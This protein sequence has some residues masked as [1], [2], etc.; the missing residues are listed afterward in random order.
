[1]LEE[2]I[3]KS[4]TV[5]IAFDPVPV[6]PILA[7][8]S[9]K[10]G[11]ARPTYHGTI[12]EYTTLC[13]KE[14]PDCSKGY[15]AV[16]WFII[17]TPFQDIDRERERICLGCDKKVDKARFADV[18]PPAQTRAQ[19]ESVLQWQ[20]NSSLRLAKHQKTSTISP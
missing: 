11:T 8:G 20:G 13:K 18:L 7:V 16:N 14:I 10:H 5:R 12:D 19:K 15:D 2:V 9:Q 3:Y 17:K 1:V 4:M 6:R